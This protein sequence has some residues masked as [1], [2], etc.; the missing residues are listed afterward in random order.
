MKHIKPTFKFSLYSMFIVSV[1]VP[2]FIASITF[3]IYYNYIISKQYTHNILN[4][5]SSVSKNIETQLI[6][7][8]NISTTCYMNNNIFKALESFNNPELYSYYDSLQLNHL[9]NDYTIAMTKLMFTSQQSISNISFFPLSSDNSF[10]SLSKNVA[11]IKNIEFTNYKNQNWYKSAINREGDTLFYPTHVSDYLGDGNNTQVISA[12]KLIINMDTKKSIGVLKI[13]TKVENLKEIIDSIDVDSNSS[14][15]IIDANS[16]TLVGTSNAPAK[17]NKSF[18]DGLIQINNKQYQANSKEILNTDWRLVY[19]SST[20][21]QIQ[22]IL[23]SG[24]ISVFCMM[25]GILIAFVIYKYRSNRIIDSVKN[26]TKTIKRIENGD[27]TAHS[28]VEVNNELKTISNALNKM[29]TNLNEHI[30][31][32]YIAVINQQKAEYKALQSQINPHFLYNTLNQF[33]A[34]NRM[35]ETKKLENSII[36]LTHLFRYTCQPQDTTKIKSEFDFL[37]E[38]LK[39]Q[40]LKYDDRLEFSIHIDEECADFEIPKLLLQPIVENSIKHG[41][42][43][44]DKTIQINIISKLVTVKGLGKLIIMYV[45]DNGLG[46]DITYM[47]KGSNCVG[48][49]NVQ[50][51]ISLF[52]KDSIYFTKSKPNEGTQTIIA[53][54]VEKMEGTCINDYTN[55]R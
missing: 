37:K 21:N 30:Q 50:A 48:I 38:Y 14:I 34:L 10:Y 7:L 47:E 6:E 5:L 55:S 20:D 40:K 31:K 54:M 15:L 53:F 13:D 33:I 9:E 44:T 43:P 41:M 35:G 19:L 51:R 26:I 39:L 11:N 28:N 52:Q 36:R 46:Y 25:L 27:L 32:E 1:L 2:F 16:K 12:I 4:I 3:T 45:S 42:E 23:F 49:N 24:L 22:R 17:L 8:N 29:T 18:N